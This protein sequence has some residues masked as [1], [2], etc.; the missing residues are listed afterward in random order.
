M[1]CVSHICLILTKSKKAQQFL[2]KFLNIKFHEDM[3]SGFQAVIYI[4][5]NGWTDRH[6]KFKRYST[7]MGE[8]KTSIAS[9]LQTIKKAH[10]EGRVSIFVINW[11]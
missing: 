2:T 1:S 5:T 9:Y 6:G 10:T 11:D 4:Q 3:V 8:P 7:G